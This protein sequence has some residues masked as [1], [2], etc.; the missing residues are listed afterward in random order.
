M[1]QSP[2]S[3]PGTRTSP[4][5]SGRRSGLPPASP[6][7][8]DPCLDFPA[9]SAPA[10]LSRPAWAGQTGP[11]V[12]EGCAPHPEG[13]RPGLPSGA[14]CCADPGPSHLWSGLPTCPGGIAT[15]SVANSPTSFL[16]KRS[17]TARVAQRFSA[18]FSPGCDPGDTG[19]NPTSGSLHGACFFLCLC[20]CLFLSLCL[21]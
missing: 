7:P 11:R 17:R 4:H 2:V 21:S 15:S 10:V 20:L 16:N 3:S 9:P 12:L 18:A 8:G 6:W 19:S 5:P 1:L 14:G 13:P